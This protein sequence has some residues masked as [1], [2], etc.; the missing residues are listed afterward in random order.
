[1]SVNSVIEAPEKLS[2]LVE[3]NPLLAGFKGGSIFFKTQCLHYIE[4]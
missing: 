1:M 2:D 3:K 4:L